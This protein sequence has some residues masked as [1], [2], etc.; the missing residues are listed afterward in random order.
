VSASLNVIAGGDWRYQS[1]QY[2][3][4]T[5]QTD[6]FLQQNAYS[7]VNAHVTFQSSDEKVALTLY[8]HNALDVRYKNHALPGAAGA[9]GDTTIWADPRT[10]GA[11]LVSRWW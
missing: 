5:G 9:T 6:P 2:F 11:T 4:T 8:A 1:L 3:Y 7:L 10:F